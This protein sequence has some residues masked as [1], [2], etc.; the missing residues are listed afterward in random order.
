MKTNRKIRSTARRRRCCSSIR[1]GRTEE[2]KISDHED[3]AG[4]KLS[5]IRGQPDDEP[6]PLN[7][8]EGPGT[9]EPLP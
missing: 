6:C 9:P 8:D 2:P 3:T 7:K 5:P 1:N 4:V